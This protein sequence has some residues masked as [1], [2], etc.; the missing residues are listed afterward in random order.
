[1]KLAEKYQQPE[2]KVEILS[3]PSYAGFEITIYK[4]KIA[5]VY[6]QAFKALREMTGSD[7]AV[8]RK[9]L[10]LLFDEHDIVIG[11]I[12]SPLSQIKRILDPN[13]IL[14]NVSEHPSYLYPSPNPGDK[15]EIPSF[16]HVIWDPRTITRV[17]SRTATPLPRTIQGDP[18]AFMGKQN[19]PSDHVPISAQVETVN[20]DF[21]L[22]AYNVADPLF[23]SAMYPGAGQGFSLDHDD[24]A[25]RQARLL[26]QI[27]TFTK[28]HD[29]VF[30]QEVPHE[31][32][33]KI[34]DQNLAPNIHVTDM[35]DNTDPQV[36]KLILLTK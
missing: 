27:T 16:D 9:T 7:A 32:A 24:E 28:T 31:L 4:T 30:L 12:N 14:R 25:R 26:E 19:I 33:N 36:S 20:G 21:S 18:R 10:E 3:D 15:A 17:Q 8:R 2:D 6:C 5:F 22:C 35:P 23:W 13:G 1:M 34:Q 11:D 29:A